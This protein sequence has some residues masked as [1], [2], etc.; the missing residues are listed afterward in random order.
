MLLHPPPL[1]FFPSRYLDAV[2]RES[3]R[4]Q[5]TASDGFMKAVTSDI[6]IDGFVIPKGSMVWIHLYSLHR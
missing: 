5:S 3:M 1:F 6:D 4:L 2:W